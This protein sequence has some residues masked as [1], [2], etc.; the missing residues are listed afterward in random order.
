MLARP[1]PRL[2]ARSVRGACAPAL[3]F[4]VAL[5]LAGG[6]CGS[7]PPP[8]PLDGSR[9]VPPSCGAPAIIG[10]GQSL[11][12]DPDLAPATV[13]LR[14]PDGT[15][16]DGFASTPAQAFRYEVSGSG[17]RAVR[18][19]TA[20]DQTAVATDTVIAVFDGDCDASRVAIACFD[21][22]RAQG[23][24]ERRAN[25]TVLGSSG[26]TLTI[27]VGYYSRTT[28]GDV[29]VDV[30][31]RENR[32]PD[33]T[34]AEALFLDD[35]VLLW[36]SASD[37]DGDADVT[38][39]E[40]AFAGPLGELVRVDG[41]ATQRVDAVRVGTGIEATLGV[42]DVP[43]Q[44]RAVL[45]RAVDAAGVP[46]E[47]SVTAFRA[48]GSFVG[49]TDPCDGARG[50]SIC[51]GE[52]ECATSGAS[53]GTCQPSA[54]VTAACSTAVPLTLTAGMGDTRVGTSAVRIEAGA[55]FLRYPFE[56]CPEGDVDSF[57]PRTQGR[58]GILLFTLPSGRWDVLAET[59]GGTDLDTILYFRTN[60]G[61][62]ES[63][64]G[65]ADDIDYDANNYYSRLE[66]QDV[67]APAAGRTVALI[68]ELWDGPTGTSSETFDV[69]ITLRPVRASGEACDSG[70][71][72]DR[73][74]GTPCRAGT[75]P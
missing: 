2:R 75:C 55:G 34:G 13:P 21:D 68:A 28:V 38:G 46:S 51:V 41:Y 64:I 49:I 72:L 67:S 63:T 58:E 10:D 69:A 5:A 57:P 30:S 18:I 9:P 62:P 40:L 50:P 56:Q 23:R 24:F 8:G 60:C 65:C 22:S 14:C 59:S 12:L 45:V 43:D 29:T 15:V 25:G 52:L 1:E 47:S 17:Q 54:T 36:A 35:R 42:V 3:A 26:Q 61:D 33:I 11:E 73:C 66:V 53:A 16:Y 31:S 6:A 71:Q 7:G 37:P 48:D 44:V 32:A 20:N 4:G 39:L 74:E 70:F 27:V 19:S